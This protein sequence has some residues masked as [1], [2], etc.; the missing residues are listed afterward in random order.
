[1]ADANL[2]VAALKKRAGLAPDAAPPHEE[3]EAQDTL[4]DL[5]GVNV[6]RTAI[7]HGGVPPARSPAAFAPLE[8]D[9]CFTTALDVELLVEG[10]AAPARVRTYFTPPGTAQAG[11]DLSKSTVVVCHHGA[12]ADALSFA[13]LAKEITRRT[14]GELGILAYDCRAHGRTRFPAE[15]AHDVSL[16]ALTTDLLDVV[17]TLF[18]EPAKRPSIVLVGHSMGGAVAVAAAHTLQEQSLARVSG[19]AMLD[20]VEGTSLQSLPHMLHIIQRRPEGFVNVEAAIQWHVETRALRNLESA[21][22]S[23]P[24]L[25]RHDARHAPLPWRWVTDLAA[26]EPYWRGWFTGLS[27]RFLTTRAPRL[28]ILAESDH[29]DQPL[30]IGQ[31]QGKFQLSIAR[32]AGHCVHETLVQFWE[33]NERPVLPVPRAHGVGGT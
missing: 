15:A 14:H 30:M 21:R 28:L 26:T 18:P 3:L 23:V 9:D 19:V 16:G 33:R 29:L 32:E 27:E 12:G 1:M 24:S 25:L 5:P 13:L 17:T 10:S 11:G 8:S 31:M 22:R 6:S 20:I 4:G 7:E 2:R